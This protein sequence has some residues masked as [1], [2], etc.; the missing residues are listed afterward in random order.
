MEST[1]FNDKMSRPADATM[2]GFN[3]EYGRFNWSA[4][5]VPNGKSSNRLIE[6]F[7]KHTTGNGV[8]KWRHYFDIYDRHFSRFRGKEVHIV[9]I[10]VYGGGSLEMWRDY[11]GPKARI[12]GVDIQPAYKSYENEAV[13]MFIGDQGDRNFWKSFRQAVPRVDIVIDDGSHI[14]AH[15]AIT[16]EEMLPHVSPGGV[17]LCEDIAGNVRHDLNPAASYF[18]GLGHKLNDIAQPTRAYADKERASAFQANEFQQA[19]GS[20]HL[21]PMVCVI[22]RNQTPAKEFISQMHGTVWH[23]VPQAGA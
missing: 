5:A 7:D 19:V 21:Y 20:I 15:Q 14:P 18:H 17:F 8:W 23:P 9:E 22:E 6:F 3:A 11:F 10:G 2:V 4:P 12:Y 1:E 13:Q 16:L